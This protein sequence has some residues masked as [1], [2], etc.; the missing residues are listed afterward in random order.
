M[1]FTRIADKKRVEFIRSS[2]LKCL[3]AAAMVLDI[4]CGN[5]IISK[6]LALLGYRVIAIDVS[7]KTIALARSVNHHPNI[8]FK[9][10][11][12]GEL[13]PEP[14]KYD[15]IICSEV[16]EHLH[17]PSPLLAVIHTSLKQEG[18][19]IVTVPNGRGPRELLV[20]K[21]VQYLQSK[22]NILTRLLTGVKRTLGYEGVTAQSSAEDLRHV[23]FFHAGSLAG[24][25]DANGFHITVFRKT[26]FIEQVFPFSL[27]TKRSLMLQKL[28]CRLAGLLPL[29]FTSGFMT[30]WKKK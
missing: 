21:P 12:A 8:Q 30:I 9:V 27:L 15:A 16:L 1:Q 24:L 25:A 11:K 10:V 2:L 22:N 6:E 14:G 5:G 29:A 7:E 18:T 19:L 17:D 26:N 20:T 28:D 4:G 3:P 13:Q 23:Q